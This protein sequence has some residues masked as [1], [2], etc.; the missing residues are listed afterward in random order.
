MF[1]V[2]GQVHWWMTFLIVRWDPQLEWAIFFGGGGI[3]QH[4]G[5]YKNNVALR[6]G[7]SLPMAE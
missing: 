4:S 7:C 3:R 6:C 1:G 2:V 5:T